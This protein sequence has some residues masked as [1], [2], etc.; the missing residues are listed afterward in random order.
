VPFGE[1]VPPFFEW[2][3]KVSQEAGDFVPGTRVV[4]FIADGHAIGPFICYEAA[5]PHLV[6]EVAGEA[7]KSSRT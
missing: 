1:F 5:F 7:P 4:T 6:R 3:N 2:V